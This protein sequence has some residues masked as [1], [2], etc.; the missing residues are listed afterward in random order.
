MLAH[1]F[2][3][4]SGHKELDFVGHRV[5]PA[6]PQHC[7]YR[8]TATRDSTQGNEHGWFSV[9]LFTKSG[10]QPENKGVWTRKSFFM[11]F[12]APPPG[13]DSTVLFL[14]ILLKA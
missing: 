5:C 13:P 11:V 4:G 7:W 9:E 8:V 14:E 10:G 2:C 6:A 1:L 12:G 3:G